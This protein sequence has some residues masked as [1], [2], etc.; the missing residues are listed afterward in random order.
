MAE[1]EL[2]LGL[3]APKPAFLTLH[4]DSP[5]IASSLLRPLG[6]EAGRRGFHSGLCFSTA[7]LG[8]GRPLLLLRS[9]PGITAVPEENPAQRVFLAPDC[10]RRAHFQVPKGVQ[11]TDTPCLGPSSYVAKIWTL[12]Y[13]KGV[14]RVR[15]MRSLVKGVGV[16]V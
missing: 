2:N 9:L 14:P 11:P 1:L 13:E 12:R 7:S 8:P 5:H 16:Q 6:S 3:W 4:L 15:G 10:D